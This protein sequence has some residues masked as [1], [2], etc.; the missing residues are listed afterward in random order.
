MIVQQIARESEHQ[1]RQREHEQNPGAE[2]VAP[3]MGPGG[4]LE[5]PPFLCSSHWSSKY[6]PKAVRSKVNAKPATWAPPKA[7]PECAETRCRPVRVELTT[8]VGAIHV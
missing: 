1:I 6:A 7:M 5:R 4:P 3:V 2:N 8:P